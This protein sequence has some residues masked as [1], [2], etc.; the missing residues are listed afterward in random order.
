MSARDPMF[1]CWECGKV[2]A[3]EDR[4]DPRHHRE[5]CEWVRHA[6]TPG[7]LLTRPSEGMTMADPD[8]WEPED[9]DFDL[10]WGD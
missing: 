6:P 4:D 1:R 9:R 5:G 10:V 2:M 3:S 8:G 7:P